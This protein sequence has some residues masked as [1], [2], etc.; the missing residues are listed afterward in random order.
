MFGIIAY[1]GNQISRIDEILEN[2][3]YTNYVLL[4][5]FDSYIEM[6]KFL[7]SNYFESAKIN[8]GIKGFWVDENWTYVY[9]PEL[10]D[11]IDT[12]A[13]IKTS[14]MLDCVI[15]CLISEPKAK[16]VLVCV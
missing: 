9:D 6:E 11:P 2:F 16:K 5:S 14:K 7:Y 8:K 4:H 3:G 15:H 1:K 10:V 12:Q 13:I